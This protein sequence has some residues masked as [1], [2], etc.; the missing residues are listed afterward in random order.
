M[1]STRFSVAHQSHFLYVILST[2][3]CASITH[4][5]IFQVTHLYRAVFLIHGV[6][7]DWSDAFLIQL[8]FLS[9][10]SNFLDIQVSILMALT[11]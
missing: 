11:G 4:K 9:I 7:C 1:Y 6:Y 10:Y 8:L 3:Q 2:I 5:P